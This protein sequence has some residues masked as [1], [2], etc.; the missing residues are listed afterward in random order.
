ME[1]HVHILTGLHPTIALADFV[2][3][4]KMASSLWIKQSKLFPYFSGW[5]DGYAALT[6]SYKD[7]DVIINYIKGQEMHHQ[8][9][10][11]REE[12]ITLMKEQ[13][14]DIDHRFFS[15]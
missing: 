6:Y 15:N 12:L 1:D 10:S 9:I 11:F 8:T 2:R 13:G 4:L 5:G 14:I 7:K 3:D